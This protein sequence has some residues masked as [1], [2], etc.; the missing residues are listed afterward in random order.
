MRLW[1]N[2]RALAYHL[3]LPEAWN[4]I[5]RGGQGHDASGL[6]GLESSN[7]TG[8]RRGA[9]NPSRRGRIR[10]DTQPDRGEVAGGQR[11]GQRAASH[12]ARRRHARVRRDLSFHAGLDRILRDPYGPLRGRGPAAD[13]RRVALG[14]ARA[15]ALRDAGLL[16]EGSRTKNESRWTGGSPD[17]RKK[18]GR[19]ADGRWTGPGRRPER[20][21][22]RPG[23]PGKSW[24]PRSRAY[25]RF[26][27]SGVCRG[28]HVFE[29]RAS[30]AAH[31]RDSVR[32]AAVSQVRG[33]D[34]QGMTVSRECY[35]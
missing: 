11:I 12:R 21:R 16:H 17:A 23:R 33:N 3:P 28:M 6:C 30:G 18:R 1:A 4:C 29:V 22:K 27:G 7:R 32:A 19:Y 26:E 9:S 8:V 25:G 15:E 34:E 31:E 24:R 5:A 14:R 20:P 13:H 2:R 10:T 35:L